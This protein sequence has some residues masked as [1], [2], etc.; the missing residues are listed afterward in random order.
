MNTPPKT[1]PVQSEVMKNA[2]PVE[3]DNVA[4]V[5]GEVDSEVDFPIVHGGTGGDTGGGTDGDAPVK[6]RSGTVAQDFRAQSELRLSNISGYL[7]A[8]RRHTATE[9]IISA[10]RDE[11]HA[12]KYAASSAGLDD[13]ARL[14][15][16]VVSLL[17]Q[18]DSSGSN[19]NSLL[20]LLEEAHDGLAAEFGFVSST[21]EAHLQSLISMIQLLLG[22]EAVATPDALE[23]TPQ[24]AHNNQPQASLGY[25]HDGNDDGNSAENYGEYGKQCVA[26]HAAK[27]QIEEHP[28][29]Q[30]TEQTCPTATQV[31]VVK[32]GGCRVALLIRTIERVMRV[33]EQEIQLLHG[34]PYIALDERQ[35]LLVDLAARLGEAS[36]AEGAFRHLVVSRPP[37]HLVAGGGVAFA[38]DQFQ[39]VANIVVK[40][41][42]SQAVVGVVGVTRLAD[43][44]LAQVLDVQQ[45]VAQEIFQL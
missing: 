41:D 29:H 37:D 44:S 27:P 23:E 38:I 34:R 25:D 30:S 26:V 17:E 45:F 18:G 14:S 32:I 43:A 11:F 6:G 24:C 42:V 4:E 13:V 5:A 10:I 16:V 3:A 1:D 8:W 31:I 2:M 19:D 12:L 35:I 36:R 15:H 33:H 40:T 7:T 20:N 22:D 21:G 39:E 28:E 9:G